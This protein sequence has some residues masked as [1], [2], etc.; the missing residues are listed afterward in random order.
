MSR[1]GIVRD[2]RSRKRAL[3]SVSLSADSRSSAS[4]LFVL[5]GPWRSEVPDGFSGLERSDAV[6]GGASHI[7]GDDRHR[8]PERPGPVGSAP[9]HADDPR[10]FR[11][12]GLDHLGSDRVGDAD[13]RRRTQRLGSP[14]PGGGFDRRNGP[15]RRC[16]RADHRRPAA[17]HRHADADRHR[18]GP[19]VGVG[20]LQPLSPNHVPDRAP[21]VASV[22]HDR[23]SAGSDPEAVH[24]P[25]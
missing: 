5:L 7:R 15:L 17:D 4:Y 1:T 16:L 12:A 8:D 25:G 19:G 18:V 2:R 9:Q 10:P 11:D 14:F 3:S 22:P 23:G 20:P 13:L 24:R 6:P 21:L